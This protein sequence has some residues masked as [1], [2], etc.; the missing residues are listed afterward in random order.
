MVDLVGAWGH[1]RTGVFRRKMARAGG[2]R[3]D[4]ERN[5]EQW[6]RNEAGDTLGGVTRGDGIR[7]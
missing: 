1:K 7:D 4:R 3:R 5:H 6:Q 2:G